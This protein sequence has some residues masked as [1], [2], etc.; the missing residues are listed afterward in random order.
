MGPSKDPLMDLA[1][2]RAKYAVIGFS[3]LYEGPDLGTLL[4]GGNMN[5]FVLTRTLVAL[6]LTLLPLAGHGHGPSPGQ[7]NNLSHSHSHAAR[8]PMPTGRSQILPILSDAALLRETG[9]KILAEDKMTG[10]AFARITLDEQIKI[11]AKAHEWGRCG[12]HEVVPIQSESVA[13]LFGSLRTQHI[14]NQRLARAGSFFR[15]SLTPNRVIVGAISQVSEQNLAEMVKWLSSYP[16]RYNK[17]PSPN[18]HV[19]AVADRLKKL[20]AGAK[21]PVRIELVD[22]QSTPQKSIRLRIEGKSRPNEIVVLG[23]HLDSIS[24]DWFAVSQVAPGADDNASGSSNLIE[25][26]RILARL[27]QPERTIDFFWYAGE[28]SGLLGSGEIARTYKANNADVIGV[29][30]LDMTLFPG[31]GE[32]VLGSMTDFTSA[33]LREYLKVL[34][35]TY[36][37][38]KIM[39]DRCGYG[40]SDHASWHRQGYPTL[41]PFESSF[42]RSN[43]DI[44]TKRDV[45]NRDS[46]FR[47]SAMFSKIAV[48]F[49]LDLGN[50]T[51]R[52]PQ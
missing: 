11:S 4:S 32:F 44:H 30:Q 12:G 47:H 29:L 40:C 37:K 46:N 15:R 33:W 7:L 49:A 9:V 34:N 27:E 50:S 38:A 13:S 43:R 21:F 25:A 17:G 24:R 39:E 52:S 18:D 16:T 45:I 2:S 41:M 14:K 19:V 22:H 10:V 20:T 1:T 31:D 51:L 8:A 3:G 48:A 26:A 23:G 5:G 28:E 6:S 42:R 36:I 35:E